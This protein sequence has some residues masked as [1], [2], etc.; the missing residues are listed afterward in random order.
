[1][2]DVATKYFF[3]MFLRN[4]YYIFLK[5]WHLYLRDYPLPLRIKSMN[6]L[7]RIF[8][9]YSVE[10]SQLEIVY[11]VKICFILLMITFLGIYPIINL[12]C[13]IKELVEEIV[14]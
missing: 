5:R 1:M 9:L 10:I 4:N 14:L 2:L 3:K 11:K 13:S 7:R 12:I 6:R 8:G